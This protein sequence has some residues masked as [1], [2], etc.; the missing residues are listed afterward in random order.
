MQPPHSQILIR[1]RAV[2]GQL[3]QITACDPEDE[4][5]AIFHKQTCEKGQ[6]HCLSPD[7]DFNHSSNFPVPHKTQQPGLVVNLQLLAGL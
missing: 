6:R 7:G 3:A 2:K 4:R 5:E 1:W